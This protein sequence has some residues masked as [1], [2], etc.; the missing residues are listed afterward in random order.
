MERVEGIGG[1]FV[2]ARDPA[3]L[4]Q[5]YETH[6]GVD[7]AHGAWAPRG[8][9][10]IFAPFAEDDGYF[11]TA[12]RWMLNFRVRDLDA[13]TAQLDAAGIAVRTDPIWTSEVG[14]FA[15]IHDPEG[16]PIELWEPSAMVRDHEAAST[17][18]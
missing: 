5:W 16:N 1:L 6:L 17:E 15:R 8:G 12:N 11:P 14:R 13:M 2:W 3:A 18:R 9:T 4:A 10:T 7:G